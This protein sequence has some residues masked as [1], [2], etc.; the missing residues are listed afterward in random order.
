[1]LKGLVLQ[2]SG[3]CMLIKMLCLPLLLVLRRQLET[4]SPPTTPYPG[5]RFGLPPPC[6]TNGHQT[7]DSDEKHLA[8]QPPPGGKNTEKHKDK[9]QQQGG[10]KADQ[11]PEAPG[12]GEGREPEDPPPE[13]PPVPPT[14][15]GEGAVEGGPSPGPGHGQGP[16]QEGILPGAALLLTKWEQQFD[17]LVDNIVGELRD[18]WQKLRT[19]Q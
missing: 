1:M 5:R 2:T 19:P 13:D 14:G 6:P 16:E 17:L 4:R 8:L 15:T 10:E 9:K 7:D 12:V 11:G 3:K 18:Y